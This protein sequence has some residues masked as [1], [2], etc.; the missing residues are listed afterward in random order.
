MATPIK[1]LILSTEITGYAL[2][3][4]D[5]LATRDDIELRVLT[6]G[7]GL[8]DKNNAFE[9]GDPRPWLTLLGKE[10]AVNASLVRQVAS[11][12]APAVIFVSG[13]GNPAYTQLV[14]QKRIYGCQIVLCLD[15]TLHNP[16]RQML[17]RVRLWNY[18]R[19]I[20]AFFVPGER[21][22]EF[23][24]RW[25]HIP[26]MKI[27]SGLYPADVPRWHAAHVKRV[28]LPGWP[29]S[30]QFVGRYIPVKGV[31]E[32][33]AGYRSYRAKVSEPMDFRFCGQGILAEEIRGT[34][35]MSDL[36]FIQPENMGET[37]VDAGCFVLPSRYD[38]WAVALVEACAAGLPLIAGIGC[39][40][41]AE[42]L[43]DNFNGVLLGES[44]SEAISMALRAMHERY[45]EW[46]V[47]G[48]RSATMACPYA[49]VHWAA[50]VAGLVHKLVDDARLTPQV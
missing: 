24:H 45:S 21:G 22:R 36:G 3:G 17:G 20:D 11:D 26:H 37:M 42:V 29:R 18:L 12:F 50:N 27:H 23:L 48:A 4:W 39:G 14:H 31:Q 19:Q 7:A 49:P 2:S 44:S 47:M 25:W 40:A 13:W 1:V 16:V 32:L 10:T 33:I 43:R 15:T 5:S 34:Q 6:G 28:N 38:P 8:A 30:F 46:P 9:P 41:S 35:G